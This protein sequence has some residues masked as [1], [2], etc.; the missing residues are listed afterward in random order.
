MIDCRSSSE[1][2]PT[3]QRVLLATVLLA[4]ALTSV[5]S[6]VARAAGA[7][8][9]DHGVSPVVAEAHEHHDGHAAHEHGAPCHHDAEEPRMPSEV[10]GDGHEMGDC[11]V[12][13][14]CGAVCAASC[15]GGGVGAVAG[16][17]HAP[18]LPRTR[19]LSRAL[20]DPPLH[21]RAP[22]TPFRPPIG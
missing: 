22:E 16:P 13:A 19:A 20:L 1:T 7:T 5:A 21:S 4:L 2:I 6:G 15:A 11:C 14:A 10:H 17:V 18:R 12:M 3:W 9:A 8:M